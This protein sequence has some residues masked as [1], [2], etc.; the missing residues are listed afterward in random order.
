MSFKRYEI[1][2]YEQIL[3]GMGIDVVEKERIFNLEQSRFNKDR[4][5]LFPQVSYDIGGYE[6]RVDGNFIA[7]FENRLANRDELIMYLSAIIPLN[8]I[9]RRKVFDGLYYRVRHYKQYLAWLSYDSTNLVPFEWHL[10]FNNRMYNDDTYYINELVSN[11]IRANIDIFDWD[12]LFAM[13][14]CRNYFVEMCVKFNN[15]D[16]F[17]KALSK[18]SRNYLMYVLDYVIENQWH[19]GTVLVE[20]RL[21]EFSQKDNEERFEL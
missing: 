2:T 4:F 16:M 9:D 20:Q 21:A 7:F 3:H 12:F 6:I 1:D 19:E 13:P 5:G 10:D 11:F 18:L 14:K 8:R 15:A 17:A